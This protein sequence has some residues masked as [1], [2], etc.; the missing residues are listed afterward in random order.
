MTVDL[1]E[2]KG[3]IP[4]KEPHLLP[5][6]NAQLA[7]NCDFSSQALSPIAA[8]ALLATMVNNPVK[9]MYTEDGLL[10]YTWNQET[11]AFRSPILDDTFQRIYF[12]TP[13]DGN[14]R[15]TTKA[16]MAANGPT[17]AASVKAGVPRPTA[18]PVLTTVELNTLPDYPNVGLSV[19]VWWNYAGTRYAQTVP[20]LTTV[21]AFREYSFAAPAYPAGA[22]AGVPQL[23][24]ELKMTDGDNAGAV[25]A[26]ATFRTG[27][28]GRSNTLPGGFEAMVSVDSAG[29]AR[30]KLNWAPAGAAAYTYT[31]QNSWNEESAPSPPATINAT[32]LQAVKVDVTTPDFTG[33]Q[34]FSKHNIYR[35]Y[36]S[37]TTYIKTAVTTL[38]ANSYRDNST[39]PTSV[40][41]AL[42]ST[43]WF[44]P[45]AGLQ[46]MT[47]SVAGGWFATFKDNVVY[48][49]EANTPHAYPYTIL[50]TSNVRGVFAMQG[51]LLVTCADGVYFCAGMSPAQIKRGADPIDLPQQGI[52]Q[53][54]MAK[55]EGG[56]IFAS[57]DGLPMVTG[58][59]GTMGV[60]EK[61]FTRKDWRN[62]FG[63]ILNDASIRF[64]YFDGSLIA[65]S[66]TQALGF[67]L[68]LD[69][70]IGNLSRTN[71]RID[72]TFQVPVN[73]ALYYSVGANVYKYQAGAAQSY[74]W[75]SREHIY[76]QPISWGA[77]LIRCSAPVTV[78]FYCDGVQIDSRVQADGYFRIPPI[79][80]RR[81]SVRLQGT[82]VVSE[83]KIARSMSELQHVA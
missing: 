71:M 60:S 64:A 49:S 31:L 50:F 70:N 77:A 33:Y 61:L 68:R 5:P 47:N 3:E 18:A 25:I 28:T 32:Y 22:P 69:E 74:D 35:T 42:Q 76:Q 6:S 20:V 1:K 44:P 79:K 63:S 46:G 24:V 38:G 41:I 26:Q 21:S 30:I 51:G 80:G 12:L 14:L 7:L 37:G 19:T 78:T 17:P 75:W 48:L 59:M 11:F 23:E 81:W 2:F 83:L 15:V 43:D 54:S 65:T 36:G 13:A 45:I 29:A 27:T 55:V 72:A 52:A 66:H 16:G 40:G 56:V 8:G 9:G 39:K 62:L 57:N 67:V 58:S 53:R 4:A 73:D 34:P 82:A 10:F